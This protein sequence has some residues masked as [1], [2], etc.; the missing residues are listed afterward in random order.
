MN[1]FLKLMQALK[2]AYEN[3]LVLHHNVSGPVWFGT[4]EQ[5]AEYYGKI[6]EISDDVTE[7][8]MSMGIK[9]PTITECLDTFPALVVADRDERTTYL[10]TRKI[11]S[12]LITEFQ[13]AEKSLGAGYE[14]VVNKLQEYREYLRKENDYKLLR[15]TNGSAPT[16]PLPTPPGEEDDDY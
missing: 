13:A 12:D 3:L 4:H 2:V 16:P 7:I 1:E 9:E 8:G 14:D 15:A 5:L 6:D 10:E 11:F